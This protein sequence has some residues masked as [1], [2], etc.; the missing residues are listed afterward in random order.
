MYQAGTLSGNPLAMAAGLATLRALLAPG[1]FA[2]MAEMAARLAA[3]IEDAAKLLASRFRSA[4]WAACSASTS[5]PRQMC[6]SPITERP[7][8]Y[9]DTERYARYFHAMLEHGVYFAPSQFE[10]GFMSAPT[11]RR[12]S[13]RPSP[14]LRTPLRR[15]RGS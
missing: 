12:I 5:S 6:R 3:G 11:P 15:Y 8:Q 10:A 14:P 1:V 4:R 13:P 2:A 9:A 7:K